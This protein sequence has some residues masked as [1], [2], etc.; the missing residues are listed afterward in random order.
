M[1]QI[2]AAGYGPSQFSITAGNLRA[3]INRIDGDLFVNDDW[4][5]SPHFTASYGLRVESEN[6]VSRHTNWAPRIG[7]A[8]GLGHGSNAKTVLRAGWGIF[9]THL[10]DDHMMIAGRLNG[11][12]QRIYIVNKPDFFPTPAT[13]F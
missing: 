11:Q 2:Q 6:D 10:D 13:S 12:N 3:S 7:V 9:Y 5:L 4:S 8:W 1:A